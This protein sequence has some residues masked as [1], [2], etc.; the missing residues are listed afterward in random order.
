MAFIKGMM[1]LWVR[2]LIW[3]AIFLVSIYRTFPNINTV[4]QIN[5]LVNTVGHKILTS[6]NVSQ[7]EKMLFIV[8]LFFLCIV[9]SFSFFSHAHQFQMQQIYNHSDYFNFDRLAICLHIYLCSFIFL[10]LFQMCMASCK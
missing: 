6:K 9:I 1:H 7:N 5:Q 2:R 8:H 10:W 4:S 3:D